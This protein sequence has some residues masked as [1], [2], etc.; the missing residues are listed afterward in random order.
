MKRGFDP[1]RPVLA[2]CGLCERSF[3]YFQRTK[4]RR[5]CGRCVEI[6]RHAANVFFNELA[7]RNRL[8]SRTVAEEIHA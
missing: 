7:R 1:P 6:E 4:R 3:A 8:H 2:E 5:F